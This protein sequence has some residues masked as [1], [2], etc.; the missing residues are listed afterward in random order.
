MDAWKKVY[1]NED[2]SVSIKWF[3]ENFDPENYSIWLCEYLYPQELTL[4]FMSCNLIGGKTTFLY[5]NSKGQGAA[6]REKRGA[7]FF[8]NMIQFL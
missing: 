1:S 4:T 2:E 5:M 7:H 6:F 8:I 3:W